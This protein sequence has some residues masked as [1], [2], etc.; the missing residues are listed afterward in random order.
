[1]ADAVLSV[2]SVKRCSTRRRGGAASSGSGGTPQCIRG[3]RGVRH[4]GG[5]CRV[6]RERRHAA[7]VYS[8]FTK[9][10]LTFYVRW[11]IIFIIMKLSSL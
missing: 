9:G 2:F 5:R 7:K 8:L 6:V 10:L 3:H 1:M 11:S 4:A